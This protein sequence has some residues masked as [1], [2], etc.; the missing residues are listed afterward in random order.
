MNRSLILSWVLS[1]CATRRKSQANTFGALVGAAVPT[2]RATLANIGRVMHGDARLADV[3]AATINAATNWVAQ[4][5]T[6]LLGHPRA[7]RMQ[8][9]LRCS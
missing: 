5:Q 8:K 4:D 1:V 3:L 7:G 2:R 9:P 6:R